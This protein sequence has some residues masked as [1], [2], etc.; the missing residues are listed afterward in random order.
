MKP[1]YIAVFFA[2][3]LLLSLPVPGRAACPDRVTCYMKVYEF[4]GEGYGL[5]SHWKGNISTPTCWKVGH[6]CA[7]WN[8]GG[9]NTTSDY[10]VNECIHRFNIKALHKDK[11]EEACIAIPEI[12][13]SDNHISAFH[14]HC[15]K[16]PN[17]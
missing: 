16:L 10:W 14:Q 17:P 13:G 5:V 8:C 11:G 15:T 4:A 6:Q 1:T 12:K 7:P 2:A 3:V 9:N